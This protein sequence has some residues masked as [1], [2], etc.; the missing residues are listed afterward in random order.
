MDSI[1]A[2]ELDRIDRIFSG[3]RMNGWE[4]PVNPV[5]P[6]DPVKKN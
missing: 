1:Y 5:N 4:N 6:V 2:I 3:F